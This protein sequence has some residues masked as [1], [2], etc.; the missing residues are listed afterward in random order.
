MNRAVLV[1]KY[2]I[3]RNKTTASIRRDNLNFN[4]ERIAK[5]N[6]EEEIWN[7]VNEVSNPK[8][9]TEWKLK[10]EAGLIEDDQEIADNFNDFF[11]RA[12]MLSHKFKLQV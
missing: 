9:A 1:K 5:A 3:L 4:E 8:C 12:V 6:D 7:I 11:I 10:T 2:K